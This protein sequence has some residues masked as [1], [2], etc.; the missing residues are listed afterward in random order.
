M[1]SPLRRALGLLLLA[2]L[3]CEVSS[4]PALPEARPADPAAP[5]ARAAAPVTV[6]PGPPP[7]PPWPTAAGLAYR[8]VVLGGAGPEDP[9][10]MLVAIH[11][12][13]D[14]PDNFVHLFDGFAD[15]VRVILPRGLDAEP[16]GGWSWFPLRARDPD[17][18]ALSAGI[19]HAADRIAEGIDE[20]SRSRP[21]LGKPVVTGFSQGG[22]LTFALAVHHPELVGH[23]VVVGG[24][25]P[26]P[27]LPS[28][29]AEG[30]AFGHHRRPSWNGPPMT[31]SASAYPPIVALHGTADA[32]V[33]LAPTEL[34]VQALA[35]QG[36]TAELHTYEGVGHMIPETMRRDLHDRLTDAVLAERRRPS[37]AREP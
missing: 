34:A 13:G 22:M 20:L 1:P 24:W 19:R 15:P 8:E 18:D 28:A 11:G 27:L 25:L 32:A 29:P 10:P 35:E 31:A 21:T 36:I 23:A 14:H 37:P 33:P 12:L 16:E 2:A 3:A 6:D 7:E 4:A 26:P 5:P 9:L 30:K 17:V